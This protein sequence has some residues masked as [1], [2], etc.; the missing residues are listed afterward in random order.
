MLERIMGL[1]IKYTVIEI[2]RLF[3]ILKIN[4]N[5]STIYVIGTYVILKL[6]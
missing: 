3:S 6:T 1:V 2:N 5:L 4:N